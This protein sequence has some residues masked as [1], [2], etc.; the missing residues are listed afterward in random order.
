[1]ER[2]RQGHRSN[3]NQSRTRVLAGMR[4]M[5]TA[6]P[7]AMPTALWLRQTSLSLAGSSLA[8]PQ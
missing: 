7:G 8:L 6:R 5:P 4:Q 2:E 1:M 3:R